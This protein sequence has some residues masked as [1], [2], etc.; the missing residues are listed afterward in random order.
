MF[1]NLK[2]I[3]IIP[4]KKKSKGLKKKNLLK[5]KRYS[6]TELAI[7]ASKKSK[8]IDETIV[9][10]DSNNIKHHA[11]KMKCKTLKRP[12]NLC[13]DKTNANQVIKHVIDNLGISENYYIVYLQ[14]TSPFRNHIHINKA[15]EILK[16]KKSSNLLSVKEINENFYKSFTY[17]K[18]LKPNNPKLL[19]SNRQSL[20]KIFSA[21]GAIYIFTKKNFLKSNKIPT[22][23]LLPFF[24]NN[25]DSI[26]INDQFDY[27]LSLNFSKK[28]LYK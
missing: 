3:S 21:N 26:D 18:F 7:L 14:P 27:E 8:Y 11:H 24:M 6:L 22:N 23:M 12:K 28:L 1:K 19:N 4:A 17:N 2:V 20:K 15:F 10:T 5:I 16:N 25:F 13:L 9:S